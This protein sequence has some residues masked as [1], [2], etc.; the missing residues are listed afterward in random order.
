MRALS[1]FSAVCC[2]AVTLL[3]GAIAQELYSQG[4]M[5]KAWMTVAMAAL[6][7][8]FV[9]LLGYVLGRTDGRSDGRDRAGDRG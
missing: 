2:A 5:H 6:Y 7:A 3:S 4:L 9:W 8:Y 1:A